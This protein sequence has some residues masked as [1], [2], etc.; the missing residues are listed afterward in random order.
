MIGRDHQ[1]V[2]VAFAIDGYEAA[3]CTGLFGDSDR[4]IRH[5][6][7]APALAPPCHPRCELDVRIGL[8]P[9]VLPQ[10]D[11]RV[12]VLSPLRAEA[13]NVSH[14]STIVMPGPDPAIHLLRW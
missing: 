9:G 8:L 13:K 12:F 14:P 3:Q 4:R 10:R 1:L 7:V 6:F 11:R 5:E 2:E